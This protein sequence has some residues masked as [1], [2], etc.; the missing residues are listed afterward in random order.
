MIP[1][2]TSPCTRLLGFSL[3]LLASLAQASIEKKPERFAGLSQLHTAE[4]DES[5]GDL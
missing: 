1:A 3:L 5:T 2:F 4:S